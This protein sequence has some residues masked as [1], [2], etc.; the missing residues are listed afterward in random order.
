[1][2]ESDLRLES[3]CPR[4]GNSNLPIARRCRHCFH[5]LPIPQERPE[6]AQIIDLSRSF[7][8]CSLCGKSSPHHASAC[9][10]C[11]GELDLPAVGGMP[12]MDVEA[13]L[14]QDRPRGLRARRRGVGASL[15]R[16]LRW[17]PLLRVAAIAFVL[18]GVVDTGRWLSEMNRTLS[19]ADPAGLRYTTFAI[20]EL[21]RNIALA[22]CVWLLTA[23]ATERRHRRED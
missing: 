7:L 4:C 2:A 10:S 1:M 8:V 17:V 22:G 21:V 11:G 15:S 16:P 23:L 5:E 6:P 14:G 3:P 9:Q 19:P 18:W 20:Y 12:L 13:A